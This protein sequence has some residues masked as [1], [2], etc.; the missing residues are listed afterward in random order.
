MSSLEEILKAA[1]GTD[2]DYVEV[3]NQYIRTSVGFAHVA[4]YGGT[5]LATAVLREASPKYLP[6]P[7][8]G[9]ARHLVEALLIYPYGGV[10]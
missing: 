5:G 6:R 7:T 3:V 4:E 9:G 1:E 8:Q 2:L 10:I